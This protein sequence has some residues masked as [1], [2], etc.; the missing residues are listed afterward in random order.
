[1]ASDVEAAR[2]V[3]DSNSPLGHFVVDVMLAAGVDLIN[4]DDAKRRDPDTIVNQDRFLEVSR[5][6]HGL[7]AAMINLRGQ[8]SKS[9]GLSRAVNAR[10]GEPTGDHNREVWQACVVL[11]A[12]AALLATQGDANW[13]YKPEEVN[14]AEGS[15]K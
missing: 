10:D 4:R 15:A 14:V 5:A 7:H 8:V 2:K 11:G 13:P 12:K 1:M 9:E 3:A 6:L